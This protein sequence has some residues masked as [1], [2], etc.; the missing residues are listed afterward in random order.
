M[1]CFVS[2][3]VKKKETKIE[4]RTSVS[5]PFT[6]AEMAAV[7]SKEFRN[8]LNGSQCVNVFNAFILHENFN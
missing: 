8:F 6:R 5:T 1:Y 2:K 4:N 7:G 3:R